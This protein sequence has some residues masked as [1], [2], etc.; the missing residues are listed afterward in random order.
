MRVMITR[1]LPFPA[2]GV[3]RRLAT[4]ALT[5]ALMSVHA[6][7]QDPA[8]DAPKNPSVDELQ[9]MKRALEEQQ[10]K[11]EKLKQDAQKAEE[12]LRQMQRQVEEKLGQAS[13][14][15]AP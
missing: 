6:L 8:A 13:A 1:T 5:L 10:K 12:E 14:A 4:L 9:E 2:G 7:A 3:M 15:A 11:I